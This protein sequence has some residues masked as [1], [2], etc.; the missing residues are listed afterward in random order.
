MAHLERRDWVREVAG[1]NERLNQSAQ[2]DDA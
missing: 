2:G 1:I